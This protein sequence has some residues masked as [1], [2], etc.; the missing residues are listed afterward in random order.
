MLR[1]PLIELFSAQA[2]ASIPIR[3]RDALPEQV[4]GQGWA[5]AEQCPRAELSSRGIFGVRGF[6]VSC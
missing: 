6:T 1:K 4:R 3:A 2:G 5:R